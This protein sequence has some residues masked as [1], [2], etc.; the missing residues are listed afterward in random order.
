MDRKGTVRRIIFE[1]D[2][3]PPIEQW[4]YNGNRLVCVVL[5]R[6]EKV[7]KYIVR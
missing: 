1:V 5:C 4:I 3:D 2:Y 6:I 7:R